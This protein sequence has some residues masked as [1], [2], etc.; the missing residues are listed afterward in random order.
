MVEGQVQHDGHDCR[1]TDARMENGREPAREVIVEARCSDRDHAEANRGR[2]DDQVDV[3]AVVDL[4][5]GPNAAGRDSTEQ[6]DASATQY[7]GRYGG[8]DPAH[9][10]QQTEDHQEQTAGCHHVAALDAGDRHQTDVL[11][12]GALGEGTEDRREHARQHVGAQTVAQALGVNL[13][14]DDLT[15]GQN[16]RRGLHQRHHH[17]DA[18]RQDRSE[19]EGRHAEVERRREAEHRALG[20][21]R[22]IRHA[23]EHRDHRT[24]DHGQQNRQ[25]RDGRTADFAQ[26]QYQHQRYR[27]QTDVRRAA[28][29]RRMAVAAHCPARG[30]RHQR[31]AD[32]GNHDAGHQRREELGDTREHRGYQQPD[33][34]RRYHRPQHRLKPALP[35]TADNRHH[36]RDA[37]E[38]YALHQRQLTTKKR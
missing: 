7:G 3:V 16:V 13:G 20:Y 33:Q 25:A 37:G 17:H 15:D 11:G 32:G 10:G 8:D 29:V 6:H 9:E 12:E 27:R 19:V 18:H 24:N 14:A 2:D 38:G 34:G 31:Q 4:G 23:K 30:Y 36:G 28:E 21:G 26:Q 35:A 1:R 5:Q 22:K